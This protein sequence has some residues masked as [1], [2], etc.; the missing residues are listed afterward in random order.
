MGASVRYAPM[1]SKK[2]KIER[3]QKISQIVNFGLPRRCDA[4]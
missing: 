1:L 3:R 4:L 2:S